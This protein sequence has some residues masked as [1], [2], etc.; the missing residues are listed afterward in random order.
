VPKA[1]QARTVRP[2]NAR[3]IAMVK[4]HVTHFLVSVCVRGHGQEQTAPPKCAQIHALESH[5]VS[6]SQM[7]LA[8]ALQSMKAV[9]VQRPY[10]P[11]QTKLSAL[12]RQKVAVTLSLGSVSVQLRFTV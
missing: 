9:T 5:T 3:R 8:S 6:V 11:R 7:E 1:S 12:E 2:L 10:A 4:V